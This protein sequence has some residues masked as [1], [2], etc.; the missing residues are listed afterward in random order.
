M[1]HHLILFDKVGEPV[2]HARITNEGEVL[3]VWINARGFS[4]LF[5]PDDKQT[6]LEVGEE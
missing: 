4:G 6:T 2:G 5:V 3:S 1:S